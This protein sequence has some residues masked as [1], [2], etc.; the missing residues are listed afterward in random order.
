MA[1]YR[2]Y[3]FLYSSSPD[4]EGPLH[5]DFTCISMALINAQEKNVDK[6]VP[7]VNAFGI[8]KTY[9]YHILP[10]FSYETLDV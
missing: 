6:V 4:I 2:T 10:L 5:G 7:I 9:Y 8:P 3:H 1:E